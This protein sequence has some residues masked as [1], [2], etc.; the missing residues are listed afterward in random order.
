MKI[1]FISRSTDFEVHRNWLAITHSLP[2]NA[3]YK[4]SY[5][6]KLKQASNSLQNESTTISDDSLL[7][8]DSFSQNLSKSEWT[9][10][11]PPLFASMEFLLSQAAFYVDPAMLDINNLNYASWKTVTF[12]RLSVVFTDL[13]FL[14]AVYGSV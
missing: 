14:L 6:E 2:V 8:N 13:V 3:W 1:C 9:L 5:L 10:D 12:Q 11:Y 4:N 7:P